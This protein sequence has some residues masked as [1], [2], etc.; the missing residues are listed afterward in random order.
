M[1]T[2]MF[3]MG[4]LITAK[5]QDTTYIQQ[6]FTA[7]LSDDVNIVT[8]MEQQFK[9]FLWLEQGVRKGFTKYHVSIF[10]NK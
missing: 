8:S 1:Y 6:I 2:K 9:Y 10:L 3:I 7:I 4:L 5:N